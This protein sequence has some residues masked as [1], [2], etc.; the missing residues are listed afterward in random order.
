MSLQ[1]P[2][3]LL[4]Q[5]RK[6]RHLRG[7][8]LR[9]LTFSRP[10]GHTSDDGNILMHGSW[11]PERRESL[12]HSRSSDNLRSDRTRGRRVT[13]SGTTA[14]TRQ[15][16]L[17]QA[18]E[19]STAD[20][21]FSLHHGSSAD[22][23]Y[24]SEVEE[25]AANFNFR[26]FDLTELDPSASRSSLLVIKV[27]VRRAGL[28]SLLLE[29]D[30]D[31]RFLTRLGSSLQGKS[32]GTAAST[33]SSSSSSAITHFPPNSIVFQLVD[34]IYMFGLGG[35]HDASPPQ[36]RKQAPPPLPTSSYAAL[37][38]LSNLESSLQDSLAT[39]DRLAAQ[40]DD[41]LVQQ[42]QQHGG[43]S[44][45]DAEARIRRVLR[46]TA[47]QRRS[48]E[49]ARQKRDDLR[50]SLRARREA[51]AAGRALQQTALTDVEHAAEKLAAS[52]A[53]VQRT[54]DDIRGQ[55]R[56]ISEDLMRIFVMEPTPALDPLLPPPPLS[57]Q[58]CGMPLPNT[59]YG[60]ALAGAHGGLVF[61]SPAPEDVLSAALG[62]VAALT[63]ALQGYLGVV[64]PYRVK[65]YGS[66]S[67]IR[68]DI[69]KIPDQQRE[70]PLYMPRGGLGAQ[71]RFDY[72]WFLLNKN[73]ETLCNAQGFKVVDIR[74]TLPNLKYLLYVCS[75]GSEE[76][77]QRKR[78]GV[79]GL[80]GQRQAS[81]RRS[82]I[83]S[84]ADG[85]SIGSLSVRGSSENLAVAGKQPRRGSML[86][87]GLGHDESLAKQP[88]HLDLP[89][90]DGGTVLSLRTKGMREHTS[91]TG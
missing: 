82:S 68:D 69:S 22:P 50:Q 79:R 25:K 51:I 59:D 28:W 78:G 77:P 31:L 42:Q 46:G 65:P 47:H 41:L 53:T 33:T 7:I 52:R 49:L 27:W 5:N 4:A 1:G 81:W 86:R 23:L 61:G 34:G 9:N 67:I 37:M 29:D 26:L 88:D 83:D 60:P 72:A 76:L 14:Y 3:Y 13:L 62:Y 11:T 74:H 36:P 85:G 71:Y 39:Q 63:S 84:D 2:S 73:I 18:L 40:I 90:H 17:E 89:F 87:P 35:D 58:I 75:A 30:V 20:A 44:L 43:D 10:R 21:F 64:L 57:F 15:R 8:Y 6:L 32:R 19:G 24:V 48:A 70:F 38:R 16:L 56:R 45:P 12:V 66:R 55:R 80:L 54:G 91:S